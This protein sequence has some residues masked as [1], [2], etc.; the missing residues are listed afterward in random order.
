MELSNY[1]YSYD[2]ISYHWYTVNDVKSS[3][4][5][6]PNQSAIGFWEGWSFDH[7]VQI[8][9]DKG[10]KNAHHEHSKS[11]SSG[12]SGNLVNRICNQKR[13]R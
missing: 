5:T 10:N 7:F 9:H 1:L 8:H 2:N 12:S 3:A 13:D 4:L 6:Y 11:A